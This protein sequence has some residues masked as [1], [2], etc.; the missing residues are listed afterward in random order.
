M[1]INTA[2][3]RNVDMATTR[4]SLSPVMSIEELR[5]FMRREFPQ[6]GDAFEF[7]AIDGGSAS[8]RLH[9]DEQHLRPGGTV[10]GP[11]LFA[12][13]DVTAYA[14]ILAHI[15][16]VALAVTTNLNINFLR[17]PSPALSRPSPTS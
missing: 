17:K 11:S 7:T 8:M 12:L 2:Q 5:A 9:A 4:Q 16:P 6:L 14:A 10:S 15:G 1:N 3:E 13:A